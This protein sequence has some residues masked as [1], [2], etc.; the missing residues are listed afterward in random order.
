MNRNLLEKNQNLLVVDDSEDYSFMLK[1]FLSN[2]FNVLVANNIS[3]AL[4]ACLVHNPKIIITDLHL[5]NESGIDLLEKVTKLPN[6][7]QPLFFLSSGALPTLSELKNTNILDIFAKPYCPL[8]LSKIVKTH[9]INSINCLSFNKPN[10]NSNLKLGYLSKASDAF[11]GN[12]DALVASVQKRNKQ[13]GITGC[14]FFDGKN[15][16][17][18]LEGE[19]QNVIR[20]FHSIYYD[21]RHTV[22]EFAS[23]SSREERIFDGWSMERIS[24]APSSS[25]YKD[26]LSQIRVF[27][28]SLQ[29]SS[30]KK[31]D[32]ILMQILAAT[33]KENS[34]E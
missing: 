25:S 12:I 19:Y 13:E 33:N 32:K 8:S 6:K 16:F 7:D 22:N 29:L 11:D 26:F 10:L 14:L 28:S 23:I 27:I 9:L 15:F 2:E 34:V 5:D 18:F 31:L 30:S 1:T 4:E 21:P 17:Q 20:V 3:S 24:N